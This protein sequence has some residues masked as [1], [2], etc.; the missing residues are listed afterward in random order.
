M[1]PEINF[2]S[3]KIDCPSQTAD[4]TTSLENV[5]LTPFLTELI[6]GSKPGGTGSNHGNWFWGREA[7]HLP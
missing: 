4:G 7:V 1:G 2:L 3:P 5:D 6:R